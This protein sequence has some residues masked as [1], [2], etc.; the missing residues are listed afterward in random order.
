MKIRIGFVSN[1]SS[2]SFVCILPEDWNP[3]DKELI[4]AGEDYVYEADED[5]KKS[6]G[7][8]LKHVRDHIK[9]LKGDSGHTVWEYGGDDTERASFLALR[10]LIPSEFIVASWD[11]V[12]D[13]GKIMSPNMRK[14]K[15]YESKKRIRE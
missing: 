9:R 13:N 12:S 6:E 15:K 7:I 8:F 11:D 3:S 10:N 1:S 14:V 4:D 5:E 2:S